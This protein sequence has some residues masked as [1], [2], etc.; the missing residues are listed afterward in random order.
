MV[1][2]RLENKKK[3]RKQSNGRE[4][5]RVRWETLANRSKSLAWRQAFKTIL[6]EDL[7]NSNMPLIWVVRLR[8]MK[9]FRKQVWILRLSKSSFNHFLGFSFTTNMPLTVAAHISPYFTK[10]KTVSKYRHSYSGGFGTPNMPHTHR[11]I[12]TRIYI[13]CATTRLRNS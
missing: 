10:I 8:F 5:V 9:S 2:H 11:H 1:F 13:Q 7:L 6:K 12:D 4:W 3:Y